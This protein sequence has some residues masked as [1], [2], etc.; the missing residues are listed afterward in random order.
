VRFPREQ[1][2]ILGTGLT[3]VDSVLALHNQDVPCRISMLSRRGMLPRV[4]NLRV[5]TSMPPRLENRGNLRLLLREIREHIE[6]ARQADLCWRTIVDSLRSISNEVWQEL[7]AADQKRFLRH[8]KKYWEPHRHR[9]APEISERLNGY[10][11]NGSLHIIAGRLQE[12]LSRGRASHVRIVLKCGGSQVLEV[13]RIISCTGIHES[14]T[15]SPRPLIQSLM[16]NGLARANEVGIGFR[17]DRHGALLD[18]GMNPSSVF[19]TLGPP[20]RGD[21]FETTAVPE[22]RDQAAKL[23]HRI[24]LQ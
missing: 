3:A 4:H 6:T 19:F 12:T 17:A 15:N 22:I 16:D 10:K 21:L 9:M 7:P 11:A 14:Y 8:L 18:A 13:D 24:S 5:P 1:I 23:A 20:R 2:L